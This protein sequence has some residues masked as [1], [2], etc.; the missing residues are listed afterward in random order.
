MR[1][2]CSLAAVPDH[3]TAV[4]KLKDLHRCALS[5][6]ATLQ[7][8]QQT[9]DG[10]G[11]YALAWVAVTSLRVEVEPLSGR[12]RLHAGQ[13]ESS[14]THRVTARFRLGITAG[15]RLL[16]RD[17]PLNIRYVINVEEADRWLEIGCEEGVAV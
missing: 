10:G 7:R 15:M 3:G 8:E 5:H 6:V 14:I 17:R 4:V 2:Y 12:E 13:L 11:G 16:F 9:P 1:G